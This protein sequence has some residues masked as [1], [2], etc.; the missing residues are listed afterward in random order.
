MPATTMSAGATSRRMGSSMP[1]IDVGGAQVAYAEAGSGETVLL[2]HSSTSSGAQWRSLTEV[3]RTRWRVLAP[4]LYGYGQ[5]GQQTDP[6][7]SS[8]A[9]EAALALAVARNAKRIHL[10]GHSYGAAVALRFA[11]EQPERLLSL[12]LIEPVSFHLLRHAPEGTTEHRLFREVAELAA[13]VTQAAAA[14]HGRRGMMR[15]VDYWN[16]A[17]AWTRLRPDVQSMLAQQAPQVAL[18]FRAAMT[19]PTRLEA[20]REI[21]A[22]T[23]ILRGSA[24]PWPTRRIAALI[25]LILPNVRFRTIDGAG[26]MLPLT[27]REPVN[28]AIGDHLS[29][30]AMTRQRPAA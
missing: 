5:T 28:D 11:V 3:L 29:R 26:H 12:T 17:G 4:D 8:L 18:D 2:L 22:P 1:T 16:G 7:C 21:A 6:A 19:D 23:L 10:V 24:S 14:G 27:H 9:D 25:A 15:F 13:D 20:L 30:S